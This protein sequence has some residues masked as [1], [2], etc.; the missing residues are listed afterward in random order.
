MVLSVWKSQKGDAE[1]G[2]YDHESDRAHSDYGSISST[3]LSTQEEM[4]WRKMRK[5]RV[6]ACED[7]VHYAD[8]GGAEAENRALI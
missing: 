1:D 2:Y 8:W 5:A 3:L 6:G 4:T 7:D